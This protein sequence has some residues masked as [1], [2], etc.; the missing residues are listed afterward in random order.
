MLNDLL[1]LGGSL[2]SFLLSAGGAA[3]MG[4]LF[5][6]ALVGLL[7]SKDGRLKFLCVNVVLCCLV[8]GALL[9]WLTIGFWSGPHPPTPTHP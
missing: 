8:Y 4:V 2:L 5:L 7:K 3:L 9:L 1:G 6:S